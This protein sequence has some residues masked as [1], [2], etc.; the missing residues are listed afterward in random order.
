[1]LSRA[2]VVVSSGI[3]VA[4]ALCACTKHKDCTAV[5]ES[6]RQLDDAD[7]LRYPTKPSE[8]EPIASYFADVCSKL[9]ATEASVGDDAVRSTATQLRTLA[10]QRVDLLR[11]ASFGAPSTPSPAR[12]STSAS[13]AP[14]PSASMTRQQ[15]LQVAA[16]EGMQGMLGK[17]AGAGGS[18]FSALED[19]REAIQHA[20]DAYF[21]VCK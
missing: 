11:S 9:R 12:P 14:A 6:L 16:T 13:S 18:N 1:M 7:L 17:S 21:T 15:A 20:R 4:V 8:V 5:L 10:C 2:L 19:N 3:A